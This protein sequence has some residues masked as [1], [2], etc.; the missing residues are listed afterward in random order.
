MS[1]IPLSLIAILTEILSEY[2]THATLD[3]LFLYAETL[4][5]TKIDNSLK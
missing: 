4:Y 3:N 1:K 2:E 5:T